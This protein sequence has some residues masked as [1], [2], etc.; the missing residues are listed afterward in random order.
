MENSKK[1]SMD[2]K[3]DSVQEPETIYGAEQ[4][5]Q[6]LGKKNIIGFDV[7]GNSISEKEFVSDIQDALN[8]LT[9]GNLETYSSEEVKMKILG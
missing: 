7:K 9:K 4:L 8:C 5:N 6:T 2:K 1:H 3:Q